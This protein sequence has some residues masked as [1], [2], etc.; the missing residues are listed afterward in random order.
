M[1]L[2][3]ELLKENRKVVTAHELLQ[4]QQFETFGSLKED[5]II[6]KLGMDSQIKQDEK[7]KAE[8]ARLRAETQKFH[9][10]RVFHVSQVKSICEKY[11]LRFLPSEFYCGELDKELPLKVSA[12]ELN[13]GVTLNG[14]EE[15]IWDSNF[16]DISRIS[17]I[18][19]AMYGLTAEKEEPKVEVKDKKTP[20]NAYIMAPKESFRLQAKPEDPLLFYKIN[21][22]YFYLIHKWGNDL[23]WTR[24]I[25]VIFWNLFTMRKHEEWDSKYI[26]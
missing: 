9:Q 25:K 12:F 26:N 13:H 18:W 1:N 17:S 2:E 23:S 16:W 10:E 7:K 11:K 20:T 6:K 8:I 24:R 22:E 3:T 19:R 14:K 15:N 5:P 21:E 4:I